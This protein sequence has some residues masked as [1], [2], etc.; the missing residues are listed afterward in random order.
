MAVG[1]LCTVDTVLKRISDGIK[2]DRVAQKHYRTAQ[3]P[4]KRDKTYKLLHGMLYH[5]SQDSFR[6]HVPHADNLRRELLKRYHDVPA[7]GHFGVE[8]SYLA[9]TQ[10]Y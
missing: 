9:L 1:A 3:Q 2:N 4:G 5:Q 7:A 8:K 6:V 10:F